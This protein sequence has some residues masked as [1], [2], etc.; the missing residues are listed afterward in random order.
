MGSLAGI[1]INYS[2]W[3]LVHN[4]FKLNSKSRTPPNCPPFRYNSS[5]DCSMMKSERPSPFLAPQNPASHWSLPFEPLRPL[6]WWLSSTAVRWSNKCLVLCCLPWMMH[7]LASSTGTR[8]DIKHGNGKSMEIDG[9]FDGKSMKIIYKMADGPSAMFDYRALAWPYWS[10]WL[11]LGSKWPF[12]ISCQLSNW[13]FFRSKVTDWLGRFIILSEFPP[14]TGHVPLK[15]IK[16][17][18]RTP[19]HR[20][21]GWEGFRTLSVRGWSL[22]RLVHMFIVDLQL[23]TQ[24]PQVS[25]KLEGSRSDINY[26]FGYGSGLTTWEAMKILQG[27][28]HNITLQ[29]F[30]SEASS[31][32][33][34][35]LQNVHAGPESQP[36]GGTLTAQLD[37]S[38]AGKQ[39]QFRNPI[40]SR[41]IPAS[42]VLIWSSRL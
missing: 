8:P 30:T 1:L 2:P 5:P 25:R 38:P 23:A 16:P 20:R 19:C 42:F 31:G 17:C 7:P 9:C 21:L 37:S 33:S 36:N 28:F 11:L 41:Q 10:Y 15:R 12:S 39:Q 18:N 35:H 14:G 3:H 29:P 24:D 6:R 40:R 22:C 26:R 34:K 27:K 32:I 13:Q 4:R